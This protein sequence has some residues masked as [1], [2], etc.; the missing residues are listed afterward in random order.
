MV[1]RQVSAGY[2]PGK[3]VTIDVTDTE[4]IVALRRSPHRAAHEP[5][6]DPEPESE[7][8]PRPRRCQAAGHDDHMSTPC[9]T[10]RPG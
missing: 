1:A 5:A 4:L 3:T 9:D 8:A 10:G 2:T 7:P 6:A